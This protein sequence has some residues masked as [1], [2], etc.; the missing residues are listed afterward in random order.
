MSTNKPIVIG[1]ISYDIIFSVHN[2]FKKEVIIKDDSIA[3]IS[4][5]LTANKKQMYFGGTA[6][7]IGHFD[8][9]IEVAEMKKYKW[10]NLKPQNFTITLV[11]ISIF[12]QTVNRSSFNALN[13]RNQI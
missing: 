11:T 9:E 8:S 10:E 12:W 5:M 13:L 6:G 7:N 3:D 4:M 1:S 2:E